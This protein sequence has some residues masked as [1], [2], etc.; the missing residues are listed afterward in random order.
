M[1]QFSYLFFSI[2][3]TV[4]A[5]FSDNAYPY[6]PETDIFQVCFKSHGKY[7]AE[8][9]YRWHCCHDYLSN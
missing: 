1:A 7:D 6:T 3:S 2:I 8:L 4:K 9:A 5:A